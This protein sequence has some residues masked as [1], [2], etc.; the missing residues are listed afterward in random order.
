VTLTNGAYS[1]LCS[2]VTFY[3]ASGTFP[4]SGSSGTIGVGMTFGSFLAANCPA[5]TYSASITLKVA[6]SSNKNQFKTA[7]MAVSVTVGASLT[8][9]NVSGLDF[10]T[11]VPG[12]TSGTVVIAPAGTPARSFPGNVVI[13]ISLRTGSPASFTVTGLPNGAF[14]ISLATTTNPNDGAGHTLTLGSLASSPS[15]TGTL[16]GT[17]TASLTVGGTLTV[18][19]NQAAGTYNGSISVTVT[20][21]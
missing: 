3:P 12:G 13:P 20:Y 9:A 5:G 1:M 19:A 8:L 7:T 6:N 4:A 10:G 21:N 2:G 18:G 15:G 11:V 14:T 16:G 17:G